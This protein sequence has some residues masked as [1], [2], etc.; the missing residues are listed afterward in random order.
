MNQRTNFN[1]EKEMQ[2]D[3]FK[4]VFVSMLIFRYDTFIKDEIGVEVEPTEVANAKQEWTG[5]DGG[6]YKFVEKFLEDFQITNNTTDYTPSK[7][8]EDW[9][10]GVNLG[11]SYILFTKE[12]KAYCKIH[13]FNN[14]ESKVIKVCGKNTRC[15]LGIK[16]IQYN[17]EFDGED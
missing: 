11:I 6:K 5:D 16:Q 7:T 9:L 2:T 10:N 17:P 3:L 1:L 15:W 4:Q 13:N 12:L 14:V 8:M